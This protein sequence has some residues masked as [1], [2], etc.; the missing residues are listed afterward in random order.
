M[1]FFFFCSSSSSRKNMKKHCIVCVVMGFSLVW[2]SR[3][4]S[5]SWEV[6]IELYMF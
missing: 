5:L 4:S 3:I 2:F 6:E 1:F